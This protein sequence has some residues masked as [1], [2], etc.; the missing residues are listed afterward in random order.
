MKFEELW[1][2]MNGALS[3]LVGEDLLLSG[4]LYVF[5]IAISTKETSAYPKVY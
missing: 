5:Y 2:G 1:G 4:F 3:L